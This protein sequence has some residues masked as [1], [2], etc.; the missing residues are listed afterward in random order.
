M[1]SKPN[2][3]ATSKASKHSLLRGSNTWTFHNDSLDCSESDTYT[4]SL[5]LTA[6]GEDEFTCNTGKCINMDKRCD[7][8]ED[9]P[10]RSDELECKLVHRPEGYNKFLT[11]VSSLPNHRVIINITVDIENI[12][13]IDELKEKFV[14]KF[15]FKRDWYDNRLIFFNLKEDARNLNHINPEEWDELW[16]PS[17]DIN[18]IQNKMKFKATSIQDIKKIIP[19]SNFNFEVGEMKYEKNYRIF[20]GSE[21]ILTLSKEWSVEFICQYNTAKYPFDT[22]I[23]KMEFVEGFSMMN[24]NPTKLN[25]NQKISLSS[26]F[27]QGVKMCQT[28]VSDKQA[29]VVAVTLGRPLVSNVLTVFIPTTILMAISYMAR[30][31]EGDYLDMVVEVNLTVLLV[32]ATL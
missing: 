23:C 10:D 7:S 13:E 1:L 11:P 25:F 17:V 26:Y 9:C 22:Q 28:V 6:C 19:N 3:L 30:V 27:V 2:F 15:T 8:R 21:N 5:T 4:R 18:N 32:Q 20:Q 29:I 31:F 14:V 12:L 16:Y 24:L